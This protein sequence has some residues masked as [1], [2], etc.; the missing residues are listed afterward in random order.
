M[1]ILIKELR[2]LGHQTGEVLFQLL[3]VETS[4]RRQR[5]LILRNTN[6]STLLNLRQESHLPRPTTPKKSNIARTYSQIH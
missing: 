2:A 1:S 3:L 4:Q 5:E 6:L